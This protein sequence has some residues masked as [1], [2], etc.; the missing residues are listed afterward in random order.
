MISVD[1]LL[2][3]ILKKEGGFTN[4]P[5]DR[6]HNLR[7]PQS[8]WHSECTNFGITQFTLSDYYGRQATVDEVRNMSR[9]LA[10]EIYEREY[11]SGPRIHTLPASIQPVV[12]DTC[13][14]SG[15][16]LALRLLQEVLNQAGYGILNTDGALGPKTR[17]AATKAAAEMG[18]WLVNAYVEQRR[19][20]LE[21]LIARDPSQE[22]FR[23]GWMNRLKSFEAKL[24]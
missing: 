6:A 8:K 5:K 11:Y 20:F 12:L 21:G 1:D 17:D 19:M 2:E 4:D 15:A 22:R 24:D 3:D 16:R 9:E 14:H 7:R 13:V 18:P 10:K 23:K